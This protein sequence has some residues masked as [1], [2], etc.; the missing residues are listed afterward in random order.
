V[1]RHLSVDHRRPTQRNGPAQDASPVYGLRVPLAR[2]GESKG[3]GQVVQRA[4]EIRFHH[5]ALRAGPL[6][7]PLQLHRCRPP[8][9]GRSGRIYD[10]AGRERARSRGNPTAFPTPK[11]G[12]A[13]KLFRSIRGLR[14]GRPVS[15]Y[16]INKRFEKTIVGCR[17]DGPAV[18]F[19][20]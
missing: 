5:A 1:R 16:R 20:H 19:A 15:A 12:V 8:A 13:A 18:T 2:P 11:S 4:Q 3:A 17:D 14:L 10:R 6:R 7:S 9:T